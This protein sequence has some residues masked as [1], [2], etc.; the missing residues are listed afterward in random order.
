LIYNGFYKKVD[1][2]SFFNYALERMMDESNLL[3]KVN[4]IINWDELSN[5]LTA[6]LGKKKDKPIVGVVP[7]DYL[8]LFKVLV[9][10]Q[11][12]NLSDP[13]ME[14]ALKTRIDFMWFSGYGLANQDFNVPDETTI[15]RFRNKLV[16]HN[17]LE[18]LLKKVNNN[19]ERLNLKVK[20]TN[21]AILDATLIESAVNSKA[22]PNMI[23]EDR[24]EDDDDSSSNM[25]EVKLLPPNEQTDAELDKDAKW[26]K[27]GK[28]NVFGYKNF[29]ITDSTDGYIEAVD[30]RPANISEV[31]H[32]EAVLKKVDNSEPI[33]VLFTDKGYASAANTAILRAQKIGNG[34]M[35]KAWR[36]R[37]LTKKQ[38][39]RNKR[40]SKT[41]Y[42]VERTN[43]TTTTRF[44]FR[45]SKYIGIAKTQTQSY[46]VAIAHNLLK[47]ANKIKLLI[48]NIR[49]NPPKICDFGLFA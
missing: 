4:A 33:K 35:D 12:H 2:M 5:L 13:K 28:K 8:S 49:I 43:A 36:N 19:L 21:G 45:K 16:K 30:T 42:I 10:Q 40:I 7:Y 46:L 11:W 48:P 22:K 32:L 29:V 47:A 34:I 20:I 14:E 18:E 15:C 31:K 37:P 27:K 41:R 1:F 24:K 38:T 44:S 6:K 9:L 17:I 23:V 39:N 25:G 26:L 3:V